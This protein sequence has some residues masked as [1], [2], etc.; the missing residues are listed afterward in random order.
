VRILVT[1]GA[2]TLGSEFIRRQLESAEVESICVIDNFRTSSRDTLPKSSQLL[3]KEGDIGHEEFVLNVFKAFQP[4][5]VLHAAA[6]YAD[7]DD[8]RGDVSSNLLGAIN[9]LQ[10]CQSTGVERIVNLQTV[11]CYGRPDSLPISE[12]APLRPR[13]SYAISK[14]A[15][16][17]LID[18]A[19]TPSISLRTGSVLSTRLS[20]GPVPTFYKRLRAGEVCTLVPTVRDF[21]DPDDFFELLNKVLAPDKPTGIFNVSTGI[22]RS[23][24]DIYD[25]VSTY[26]GIHL[27]PSVSELSALDTPAIVLDSSLAQSVFDW[28]PRVPFQESM[29]R[30][31][32]SYEMGAI[33][34][35]YSHLR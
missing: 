1:G 32:D 14:V 35:I 24:G 22:G 25:F 6:S 18:Q 31:L 26:L 16:E 17:L 2:G 29:K 9:L 10:A 15:A 13:G 27:E 28:Q 30:V 5:V 4:N 34:E 20:I 23:T 8:W 3:V 11:L 33:G 12:E 7:P 21:L 19:H